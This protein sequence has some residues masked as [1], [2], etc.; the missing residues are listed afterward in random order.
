MYYQSI[1]QSTQG[2]FQ[3]ILLSGGISYLLQPPAVACSRR[4]API[5]GFDLH[6]WDGGKTAR[7]KKTRLKMYKGVKLMSDE[8]DDTLIPA[9]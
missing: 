4:T 8:S 9:C 1:S 2:Q 6:A 3:N 5:D 7:H